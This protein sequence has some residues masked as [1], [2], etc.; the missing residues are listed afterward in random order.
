VATAQAKD[1]ALLRA[2]LVA[3]SSTTVIT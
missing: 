2:A 3:I 1:K